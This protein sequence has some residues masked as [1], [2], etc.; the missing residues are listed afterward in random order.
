MVGVVN[1][2]SSNS[3]A[4]NENSSTGFLPLKRERDECLEAKQPRTT[5]SSSQQGQATSGGLYYVSLQFTWSGSLLLALDA[6]S[7]LNL[8]KIHPNIDASKDLSL[9]MYRYREDVWNCRILIIVSCS[10]IFRHSNFSN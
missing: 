6:K 7:Q 4:A 9:I 3:S 5:A 8:Y 1:A 10:W 2:N